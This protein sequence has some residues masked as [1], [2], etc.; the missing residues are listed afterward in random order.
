MDGRKARAWGWERGARGRDPLEVET[1]G[2]G[3]VH[4]ACQRRGAADTRE[5]APSNWLRGPLAAGSRRVSAEGPPQAPLQAKR[6]RVPVEPA[7]ASVKV[8]AGRRD[9]RL[10]L[11]ARRRATCERRRS[12]GRVNMSNLRCHNERC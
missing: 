7:Q 9:G 3:L 2:E 6:H 8:G 1:D 5:G 12:W 10:G 4:D 11:A